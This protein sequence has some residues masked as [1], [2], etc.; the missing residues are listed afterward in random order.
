MRIQKDF[1][2][3]QRNIVYDGQ[4]VIHAERY[5]NLVNRPKDTLH[6]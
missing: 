3:K 5:T 6:E 2:V 1:G 4:T